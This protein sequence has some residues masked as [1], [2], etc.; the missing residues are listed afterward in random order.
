MQKHAL[1]KR[2]TKIIYVIM[3]KHCAK[4]E[5]VEL[6]ES[7]SNFRCLLAGRDW[8]TVRNSILFNN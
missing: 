1:L 6:L 7:V 3:S 2:V 5:R 4:V 8:R